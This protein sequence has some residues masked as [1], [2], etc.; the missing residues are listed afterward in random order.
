[1]SGQQVRLSTFS[2]KTSIKYKNKVLAIS[3]IMLVYVSIIGLMWITDLVPGF[4]SWQEGFMGQPILSSL[5]YMVLPSVLLIYV[6]GN[7]GPNNR[8]V[9]TRERMK[10]SLITGGKA[11]LFMF[12]ATFAFPIAGKFGAGFTD[13][14]GAAVIASFYLIAIPGVLWLFKKKATIKAHGFSTKDA[15]VAGWIFSS[16]L[17][18]VVLFHFIYPLL[19]K[20]IIALVFVGF[21][22]EFFFRGYVQPRL[23]LAFDKRFEFLNLQFGWGLVIASALFGLIHVISP[24][25][26]PMQWAWGF[27][28]FVAGLGFGVIREKGGSFLAPAI[29]HGVTMILPIVFS[30]N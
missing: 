15:R 2:D 6:H 21:M 22:E 29:V 28:T 20:I 14:T 7:A 8:L 3:E 1:M 13:W 23:N 16:G 18:L 25:E 17:I 19:S 12:P 26:N 5:L 24:G 11:L 27:W 10:E 9:F 4:K 30:T